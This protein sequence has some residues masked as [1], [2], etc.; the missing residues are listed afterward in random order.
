MFA[1]LVPNCIITAIRLIRD[2]TGQKR[3]I[4]FIDVATHEMAEQA[5]KLNNHHLKG[6]MI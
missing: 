6:S 3:G 1:D 5:L 2:E 4:A